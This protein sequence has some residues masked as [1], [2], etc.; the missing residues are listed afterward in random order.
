MAYVN[1]ARYA[2]EQNLIA[3]Q[4]STYSITH[5]IQEKYAS[6]HLKKSLLYEKNAQMVKNDERL[7]GR[8]YLNLK[9]SIS[10]I[11]QNLI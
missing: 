2:Q 10:H 5:I 8:K 11:T 3:M 1:C 6:F 4:V 7:I 9:I